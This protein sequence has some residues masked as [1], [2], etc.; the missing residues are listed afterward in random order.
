MDYS[1]QGLRIMD[2]HTNRMRYKTSVVINCHVKA[3]TVI[4]WF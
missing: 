4:H 2:P 1:Y 3:M